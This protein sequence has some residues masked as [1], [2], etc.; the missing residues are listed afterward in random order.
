MNSVRCADLDRG[1]LFLL[2]HRRLLLFLLTVVVWLLNID[3]LGYLY[4]Q[5]GIV[6]IHTIHL[7]P[8]II[9]HHFI[10]FIN[11]CPLRK[12]QISQIFI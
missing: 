3:N 7:I 4:K 6:T 5:F 9:I 2:Y 10:Y 8:I 11:L 12:H 1:L